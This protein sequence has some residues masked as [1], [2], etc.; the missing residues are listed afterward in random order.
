MQH[1]EAHVVTWQVCMDDVMTLL[2]DVDKCWPHS[3]HISDKRPAPRP[4]P[5]FSTLQVVFASS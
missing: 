2:S 1:A 3:T 4:R 5:A